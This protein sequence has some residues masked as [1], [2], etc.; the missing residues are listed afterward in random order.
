MHSPNIT[1]KT[2]FIEVTQGSEFNWGKFAVCQFD[3]DEW[4]RESHLPV[5]DELY[6][7]RRSLLEMRGWGPQHFLVLDLETGEGAI[8]NRPGS[9][10]ADLNKHG[11]WV[12]PMFEPFLE[13]LYTYKW[14]NVEDLPRFVEL[15]TPIEEAYGYR[16]KGPI[17]VDGLR[18]EDLEEL[19]KQ[20]E[21]LRKARRPKKRG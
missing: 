17:D 9:P 1:M 2:Q 7:G 6:I 11:V 19:R 18:D 5:K 13:W 4:K 10:T 21:R 20:S 3:E 16:R 14:E 8:F 15:D 12:C